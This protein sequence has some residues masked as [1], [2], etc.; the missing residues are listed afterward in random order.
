MQRLVGIMLILTGLS[1]WACEIPIAPTQAQP[2]TTSWRRTSDGWERATWLRGDALRRPPAL[3]PAL[4]GAAILLFGASAL[5][6]F[7]PGPQ[8]KQPA[9]TSEQTPAKQAAGANRDILRFS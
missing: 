7:S 4:V 6:W 2:R 9:K 5:A 1:W 8:R 3:H